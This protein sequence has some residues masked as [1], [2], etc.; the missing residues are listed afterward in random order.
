MRRWDALMDEHLQI[1]ETRGLAMETIKSRRYELM[2]CGAWLRSRRPRVNLENVDADLMLKYL[3]TRAVFRAKATISSTLTACK[4]MGDHLVEKNIWLNNP[5]RWVKG[6]KINSGARLPR[7]LRPM[8]LKK[9]WA[10]A[11]QEPR[12]SIRCKWLAMLSLLY[13]TG[14]RR[15]ELARLKVT[16]WDRENGVLNIDG[17][18]TGRERK[19]CVGEGVWK[20]IEAYLPHRHNILEK[21]GRFDEESFFVN[22]DGGA[23]DAQ[24]MSRSI[25]NLC[26]K[27]GA[28]IISMHSFRHSCASDLLESGIALPEVQKILGHSSICNTMRYTHIVDPTKAEAVEKHPIN[29]FLGGTKESLKEA[30]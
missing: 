17:R 23:I 26:K 13:G 4:F 30:I 18:K 11:I 2:R 19:V 1:L 15:G 12:H 28:P 8:Q 20:C 21:H 14:I 16:D 6:P 7:T 10:T 27:A 29:V 9:I 25:H 5:L 22:R 3:R 24:C